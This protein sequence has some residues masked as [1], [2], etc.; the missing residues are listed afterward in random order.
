MFS[1]IS[2]DF[3]QF[4][5]RASDED[6]SKYIRTFTFI[7]KEEIEALETEHQKDPGARALQKRLAEEITVMVH[8]REALDTA[9]MAAKI[10]YGKSTSEDILALSEKQ[11]LDIFKGVAQATVSKADVDA[12]LGIIDA[13]A[14]SRS[15]TCCFS[16]WCNR[17]GRGSIWKI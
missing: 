4:W 9:L 11:F 1:N 10:L 3:Y 15:Q 16:W 13:F 12:G 14:K 5:V 7:S 6:A 8:S 2:Y 17:N